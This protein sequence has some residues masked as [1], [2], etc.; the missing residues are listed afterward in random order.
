MYDEIKML[1]SFNM[2]ADDD[3]LYITLQV[4]QL[5]L[6]DHFDNR[7]LPIRNNMGLSENEYREFL[8]SLTFTMV[9][10]MRWL[11]DVLLTDGVEFPYGIDEIYS[12]VEF[13]AKSM[14]IFI[15]V[16]DD[17]AEFFEE[18]FWDDD[19]WNDNRYEWDDWEEWD[20]TD[21]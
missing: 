15:E 17:A 20:D 7:A 1:T 9:D 10:Q 16:E 18:E 5:V 19:Y 3:I 13:E 8:S 12:T 6:D 21:W 2:E 14:H 4:H 11:N